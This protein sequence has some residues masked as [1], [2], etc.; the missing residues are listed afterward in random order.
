M[1]ENIFIGSS[2]E[3]LD[4][5]YAIQENLDGLG[6]SPTVWTQS[7]FGL[8]DTTIESL[9]K[10]LSS[11]DYAVFIFSPD[12]VTKLRKE[13]VKT[14][15]DN[16]VFE[17]GLFIG[18][19]GRKSCFIVV[20]NGVDDLHLPTDLLG[21]IPAKYNANR[22]DGNLIAALGPACNKIN[23]SINDSTRTP[24]QE[25]I[26]D[27]PCTANW[28]VA[29]KQSLKEGINIQATD[30]S[31]LFFILLSVLDCERS[32]ILV[33]DLQ[34]EIFPDVHIE[35][36]YDL[37]GSWD[38]LIK[39]RAQVNHVDFEN[40][41]VSRLV[42]SKMMNEAESEIF[43]KR[44]FINV[45]SQSLNV[46]GLLEKNSDETIYYTLLDS[47]QDYEDHRSGRAFVFMEAKGH[48]NDSQRRL[49]LKEL[50]IKLSSLF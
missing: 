28:K 13:T 45:L 20:P 38:L 31:D 7:I 29:E 1:K 39:Y 35:A 9:V 21:V 12:D 27:E 4:A 19:L 23:R 41:I 5:A 32:R 44:K 2:S 42:D 36:M 17:L 14:I 48:K 30:S 50:Q 40:M 47:N 8:S 15:R 25:L 37:M 33:A 49:F 3:N 16:V 11:S 26:V 18:A 34:A 46:S 22:D 10:A 24:E 6:Y 43:G